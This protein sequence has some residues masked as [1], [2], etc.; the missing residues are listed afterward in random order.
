MDDNATADTGASESGAADTTAM[1]AEEG[2]QSAQSDAGFAQGDAKNAP[3]PQD[4]D[5]ALDA[6]DFDGI[7]ASFIDGYAGIAK[8]IGL[9]KDTAVQLL[10]KAAEL[11]TQQDK[12][13]VTEQQNEW[14]NQVKVDKEFGG[15]ALNA[16]LAIAKKALDTWGG[17][18]LKDVLNTTGLGNHPE[19][20]RFFYRAGK[21]LSEDGFQ[22]GGEGTGRQVGT[23]EQAAAALFP[24]MAKQ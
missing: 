23:F 2:I 17:E 10:T 19:V 14:I 18:A 4:V 24:T 21:A 7:S 6:K 3:A 5:W 20:I 16:N 13:T 22:R 11:A 15:S 12:A 1:T 9:N 8:E